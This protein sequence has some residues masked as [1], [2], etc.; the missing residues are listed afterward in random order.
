MRPSSNDQ[1]HRTGN[2]QRHRTGLAGL[3]GPAGPA[4]P[5]DG[6]GPADLVERWSGRPVL[7][8]GDAML[9]E[10]R[11]ATSTRLCREAPAP[12]LT[13]DRRQ[14]AAGGAANTAVNLA[15]L[16]ARPLLVAPIGVDPVGDQVARC[17]H[18]AG[19]QDRMVAQ[20]GTRTPVKRRL[21]AADQILLREDD[22]GPAGPLP[23]EQVERLLAALVA[24]TE[25][26]RLDHAEPDVDGTGA[27]P[28]GARPD[29]VIC[30][31]GLGALPDRIRQWLIRHRDRY[32]TV[33]LD[34]HDLTRWAGLRP[35]L[36][37]PSIAEAAP[38]VGQ[39]TPDR[40]RVAAARRLLP[41]LHAATGADLVAVTLDT[42]GSVVGDRSG[43]THHCRTEPVAASRAVGAGDAYLAAL[44]LS[45]VA[46][47]TLPVA[48][49]L[50]QLAAALTVRDC[51]T[52]ICHRDAL[53]AALSESFP[54]AASGGGRRVTTP[55]ATP[56]AGTDPANLV[57]QVR[58][59]RAAGA[60]IV[61]TNGCFDV[62]HRGHVG[63]LAEAAAL[64]DLLIV[65][66]NSDH[67]VR[68]LKGPDRPVN[69]VEDRVAVLAALTSVDHVVVFEEDSPAGLIER[70]RP[71]VY[72]KGGDYPPDMVPEAPLVRRLGGAVHILGYVADRST[73]AVINRIRSAAAPAGPAGGRAGRPGTHPTPEAHQEL[74]AHPEGAR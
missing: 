49:G 19:V 68:R 70:I 48:A 22:G 20:P 18:Q 61:F 16:G 17:L 30:D 64:G 33:A 51:G 36:I 1:R 7:V 27:H 45:V 66:V 10:W 29:L 14:I 43:A 13:L 65:A 59:Q 15:A 71:D 38:A 35:T 26:I 56:A 69:P 46:G 3:T 6:T 31:Y 63:Y 32:G 39:P 42:D 40:D 52:C 50:A 55:A 37:T 58:V 34:T 67:S 53:T 73:S 44:T 62:L 11:F 72:V 5:A 9:D 41:R 12:V 8:V 57:E 21:L 2:D 54:A 24:S 60:R 28:D 23:A 4:V 25:E 74:E 47:A